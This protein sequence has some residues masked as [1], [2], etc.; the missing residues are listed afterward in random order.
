M[1]GFIKFLI[2]AG[3]VFVLV[4]VLFALR[5]CRKRSQNSPNIQNAKCIEEEK[6]IEELIPFP[7]G[8]NLTI[9]DIL[10]AQGEVVGKS[11]Y[12][13]VYKASLE[14]ENSLLLLRFLRP[15]CTRCK[16]DVVPAIRQLGLIRHPNLIPLLAFYSG[17]RGEKLLV[18]PFFIRGTLLEFIRS[19]NKGLKTW[20]KLREI[21]IGIAKGLDHLHTGFYKPLVHGN[22]KSKNILLDWNYKP[23]LSDYG[24][25]LLLNPAANQEALESL[26]SQGYKAPELIK[27]KDA[28]TE[29]DIY[30]FG[31]ILLEILTGKEPMLSDRGYSDLPTTMKNAILDRRVS[32]IFDSGLIGKVA[33]LNPKRE[34]G[35]L[36]FFQLA[37]SCCAPSPY[38]RPQIKQIIRRLEEIAV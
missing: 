21:S 2:G 23:Y 34:E 35:L 15:A 19:G 38:L 24:L 28:S 10:E 16:K 33:D 17:P 22:L 29:S 13:T 1:Q 18:H 31:I 27:M 36:A 30:C 32:E 5:A 4:S 12:G 25:H 26:T 37:M 11:S 14:R 8:E 20:E 9:H 7:G 3:S 6:E